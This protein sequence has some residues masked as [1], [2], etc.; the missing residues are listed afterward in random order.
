LAEL[1]VVILGVMIAL[2]ADSWREG[3]LDSQVA[4]QYQERLRDDVS[5]GVGNLRKVRER[6]TN[7]QV[8]ALSLTDGAAGDSESSPEDVAA[9]FLVA[10]AIGIDREELESDV[11]YQEL[12]AS[13]QLVLLPDEVRT[14]V[15]AFYREMDR[16]VQA[17]GSLPPLNSLVARTTGY[18]P[19]EFLT[20]G[21]VLQ[22]DD[23]TRLARAFGEDAVKRELR[24]LH[25][26]LVF[27]DRVFADILAQAEQLLVALE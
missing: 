10:A 15:V 16:L 1:G 13:G 8:A 9:T 2:V 20:Y 11:T 6:F 14:G 18:N 19:I 4:R 26:E 25:A 7:A 23:I 21:K 27:Y 3:V 22:A 17:L 24:E 12:I 5:R